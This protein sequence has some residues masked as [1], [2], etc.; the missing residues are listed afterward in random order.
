MP[1]IWPVWLTCTESRVITRFRTTDCFTSCC[2][3]M[4]PVR[5]P[6]FCF[7]LS[8]FTPLINLRP[9]Q[10]ALE[11]ASLRIEILSDGER[12]GRKSS[13]KPK[14]VPCPWEGGCFPSQPRSESRPLDW[15]LPVTTSMQAF[16]LEQSLLKKGGVAVILSEVGNFDF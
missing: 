12:G 14:K 5:H 9:T 13:K 1:F 8:L 6:L 16:H 11:D 7:S 3:A 10:A 2:N 4:L 15:Q